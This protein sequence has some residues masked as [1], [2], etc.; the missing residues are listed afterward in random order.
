MQLE[1]SFK[2]VPKSSGFLKHEKIQLLIIEETTAEIKD[3]PVV[4]QYI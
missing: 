3:S 4:K 2:R 1:K